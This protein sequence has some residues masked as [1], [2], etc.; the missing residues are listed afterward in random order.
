LR[1]AGDAGVVDDDVE[2]A[3]ARV[4]RC[5]RALHVIH[6]RDVGDESHR[7]GADLAGGR[8]DR[9]LVQVDERDAGAV[10]DEPPRNRQPDSAGAPGYQ[11]DTSTEAHRLLLFFRDAPRPAGPRPA[12]ACSAHYHDYDNAWSRSSIRSSGCSRPIDM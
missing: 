12:T 2:P 4:S 3:P 7:R 6:A 9:R 1:A 11:R 10:G 8:L 5:D